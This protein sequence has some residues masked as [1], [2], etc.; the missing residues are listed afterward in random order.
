M[1][2]FMLIFGIVTGTIICLFGIK[3]LIISLCVYFGIAIVILLIMCIP[4]FI[5]SEDVKKVD[6]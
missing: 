5:G 2:W 4:V 6:N 3:A 1:K